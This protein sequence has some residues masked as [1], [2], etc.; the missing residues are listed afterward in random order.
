M[1]L[2]WHALICWGGRR[3]CPS[4]KIKISQV[5]TL[6]TSIP[7]VLGSA[8][9]CQASRTELFPLPGLLRETVLQWQKVVER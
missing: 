2:P 4:D 9:G 5:M 6:S 8:K 3:L 7:G 1:N